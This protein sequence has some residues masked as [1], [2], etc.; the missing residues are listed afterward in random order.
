MSCSRGPRRHL[1][2][3]LKPSGRRR[4]AVVAVVATFLLGVATPATAAAQG[5]ID[6]ITDPCRS[7]PYPDDPRGGVGDYL[8][9][10]PTYPSVDPFGPDRAAIYGRY[11]FG[12][13]NFPVYDLGCAGA[14][15]AMGWNMWANAA[16]DGMVW[17]LALSGWADRAGNVEAWWQALD[18][19]VEGAQELA[20]R[21]LWSPT[22]L[23]F[24]ALVFVGVVLL[25]LGLLRHRVSVALRLAAMALVFVVLGHVT[26]FHGTETLASLRALTRQF[27]D[28]VDTE[29]NVRVGSDTIHREVVWRTWLA[30]TFGDPDSAVAAEYGPRLFD[31]RVFRWD[32]EQTAEKG[33]E[34]QSCYRQTMDELTERHPVEARYAKGAENT[35]Q[36]ITATTGLVGTATAA[37][38]R[39]YA[40]VAKVLFV[41]A[42]V[43]A[44]IMLMFLPF[45][46]V[47]GTRRWLRPLFDFVAGYLVRFAVTAVVAQVYAVI[48]GAV[49]AAHDMVWLL[50]LAAVVGVFVVSIKVTRAHRRLVDGR[51]EDAAK[52]YGERITKKAESAL[53][54]GA[55][56]AGAPPGITDEIPKPPPPKKK[57][58]MPAAAGGN[59]VAPAPHPGWIAA[60]PLPRVGETGGVTA[61]PAGA[62]P[63]GALRAGPLVTGAWP[64]EQ[65]GVQPA[66]LLN[67]AP[68]TG[69]P[70]EQ[71]AIP[72]AGAAGSDRSGTEAANRMAGERVLYASA[73]KVRQR[74]VD[75]EGWV[76]PPSNARKVK[77]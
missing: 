18:P 75:V 59:A 26:A 11:G 27:T 42:L 30:G 40:A 53:A 63:V 2:R 46:A 21:I 29:T 23:G 67:R 28:I 24:T 17:L 54:V 51:A 1:R 55:M 7:E 37:W 73:V 4:V 38:W 70:V 34:K 61:R 77:K 13:L 35:S 39:I 48:T 6:K 41:F 66:G 62:V 19:A 45:I 57:K 5:V 15:G 47:Y 50:R 65:T 22:G 60:R 10:K 56:A 12:G 74:P 58:T 9:P 68:V 14:A 31:C 71:L 49:L 36:A 43:A 72:A 69:R 44:V 20:Q 25:G 52:K 33:E 16:M 76:A 64:H 3:S 8:A 32:D